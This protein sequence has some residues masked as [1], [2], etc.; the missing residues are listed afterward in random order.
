[1]TYEPTDAIER[2]SKL[3]CEYPFTACAAVAERDALR[4]ELSRIEAVV[5]RRPALDDEPTL[6]AKVEKAI[7]VAKQVDALRAEVEKLRAVEEAARS[8]AVI[9]DCQYL[10]H[11]RRDMHNDTDCPVAK[12]NR[13]ALA[14]LDAAKPKGDE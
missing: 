14:A 11:A 6:A 10:H 4:A 8:C 7:S 3:R 5:A 1:M 2:E 13:A 9:D 12:R